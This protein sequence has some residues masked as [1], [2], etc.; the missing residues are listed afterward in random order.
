MFAWTRV[1]VALAVIGLSAGAAHAWNGLAAQARL[2][3]VE[4]LLDETPVEANALGDTLPFDQL[5]AALSARLPKGAGLSVA[6]DRA[7]LGD[8][9]ARV[10]ALP[11]RV[12]RG[13]DSVQGVLQHAVAQVAA[14]FA[15]DYAVRPTGVVVTRPRLAARTRA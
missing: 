4:W 12:H 6:L 1:P 11:V 13:A 8:D 15:V 3:R 2:A 5:L 7:A 9:A 10:A 14:R